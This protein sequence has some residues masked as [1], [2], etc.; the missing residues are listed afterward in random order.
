VPVYPFG[1]HRERLGH[2]KVLPSF[3]MKGSTQK[4]ATQSLPRANYL[5]EAH[6]FR[7]FAVIVFGCIIVK[8]GWHI[9]TQDEFCILRYASFLP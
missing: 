4:M 8:I 9:L 3:G 2:D 7:S 1:F 5:L 6:V